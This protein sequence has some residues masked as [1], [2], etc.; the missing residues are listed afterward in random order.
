MSD[1]AYNSVYF[2]FEPVQRVV[3]Y[4]ILRVIYVLLLNMFIDS[5]GLGL[6]FTSRRV[7]FECVVLFRSV[8]SRHQVYYHVV[9]FVFDVVLGPAHFLADLL[10]HFLRAKGKIIENSSIGNDQ[11]RLF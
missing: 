6:S 8:R 5:S 4:V 3:Y 7:V 2:R 11:N 9:S 10:F 1:F